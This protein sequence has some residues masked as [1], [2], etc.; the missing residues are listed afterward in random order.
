MHTCKYNLRVHVVSFWT[1]NLAL[2]P[3]GRVPRNR[4]FS[5]IFVMCSEI[6]HILSFQVYP[7]MTDAEIV[8]SVRSEA[9]GDDNSDVEM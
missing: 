7:V 6:F 3:V 4:V 2:V 8:E 5:S 1:I 9:G